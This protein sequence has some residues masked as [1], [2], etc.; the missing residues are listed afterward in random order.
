MKTFTAEQSAGDLY[1]EKGGS[2]RTSDSGITASLKSRLKT[3]GVIRSLLASLETARARKENYETKIGKGPGEFI[4]Y[5]D[6]GKGYKD[7]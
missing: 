6:V 3:K 5:P 2:S 7:T 4:A 1:R